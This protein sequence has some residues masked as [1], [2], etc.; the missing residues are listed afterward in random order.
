M[1]ANGYKNYRKLVRYCSKINLTIE[2]TDLIGHGYA[3]AYIDFEEQK[4]VIQKDMRIDSKV[5]SIL[6][7]IGHYLISIDKKYQKEKTFALCNFEKRSLAYKLC[8]IEEEYEAWHRGMQVAKHLKLKINKRNYEMAKV[9][10]L[11]TYFRWALGN[12]QNGSN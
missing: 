8:E 2:T 6:H 4:I 3:G 10:A 12:K 1:A 5:Y 7:E 11:A 9:K